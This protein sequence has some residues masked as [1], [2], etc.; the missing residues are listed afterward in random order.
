M[1]TV[2]C[3]MGFE[4]NVAFVL[5][6]SFERLDAMGPFLVADL[7]RSLAA[8]LAGHHVDSAHPAIF[9]Q[10]LTEPPLLEVKFVEIVRM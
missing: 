5:D 8:L 10:K 3:E 2:L 4:S 1:P 6:R 9:V 7:S